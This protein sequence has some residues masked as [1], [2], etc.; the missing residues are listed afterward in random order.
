VAII[1]LAVLLYGM[2]HPG[3]AILLKEYQLSTVT[4]TLLFLVSRVVIQIPLMVKY[5]VKK[6]VLRGNWTLL[7]LSGI[8]GAS[9]HF[10][11]FKSLDIGLP[12]SLITFLIFIH[13][14]WSMLFKRY[15]LK[16]EIQKI[17]VMKLVIGLLGVVI[18]IDPFSGQMN[19]SWMIIYPLLASVFLSGWITLVGVVQKRGIGKICFSFYYDLFSLLGVLIF[20]SPTI[21][22]NFSTSVIPNYFNFSMIA[23]VFAY[24]IIIGLLPNLLI[25]SG[26]EKKGVLLTSY[27]LLLEPVISSVYS[28]FIFDDSFSSSFIIG[29]ILIIVI[30]TNLFEKFSNKFMGAESYAKRLSN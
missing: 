5:S 23:W 20:F 30:N 9:L 2:T 13:P 1:F 19:L 27:V 29:A 14:V 12:V 24:S 7:L 17:D 26:V 3:A 8:C 18:I 28:F 10:L 15:F 25:Y 21:I 11:E 22:N 16:E 4:F 6:E